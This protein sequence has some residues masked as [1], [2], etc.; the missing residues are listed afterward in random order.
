MNRRW[1]VILAFLGAT[2]LLL[3][4][5]TVYNIIASGQSFPQAAVTTFTQ[6]KLMEWA[7][8]IA[9]W[10]GIYRGPNAPERVYFLRPKLNS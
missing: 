9:V 2:M 4:G 5:Y 7:L 3:G 8:W 6:I 10:I 1:K